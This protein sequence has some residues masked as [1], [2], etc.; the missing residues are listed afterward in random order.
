[1]ESQL[2]DYGG[3]APVVAGKY[4]E[5]NKRALEFAEEFAARI[6]AIKFLEYT[7]A[8]G[9]STPEEA[10][11][12]VKGEIVARWGCCSVRSRARCLLKLLGGYV[13]EKVD[14]LSGQ[15]RLQDDLLGRGLLRREFTNNPSARVI[16][17]PGGRR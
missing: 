6:A 4:G 15:D 16:G 17:R 14:V 13:G 9:V 10:A 12:V 8:A 2:R 11:A 7:A 3:V 1:M 5:M